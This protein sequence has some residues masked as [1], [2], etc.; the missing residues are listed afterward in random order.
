MDKKSSLIQ[1]FDE[2]FKKTTEANKVFFTEGAKYIKQMGSSAMKGENVYA[3]QKNIIQDAVNAFIKLNIQH[4]SNLIDLGL[5]I[6]QKINEPFEVK[7]EEPSENRTEENPPAFILEAVGVPGGSVQTEFQLDNSKDES[8]VCTFKQSAFESQQ[9]TSSS[10]NIETTFSPQSFE[11]KIGSSQ[12]VT[13]N[14]TIPEKTKTGVYTSH[15]LVEGFE[16]TYFSIILT[17][18]PPPKQVAKRAMSKKKSQ[19]K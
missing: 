11:L 19:K 15:V 7:K 12:K 4:T 10:V 18:A 1:D 17:I 2:L 3:E 16:H 6:T 9:D 8:I 5:A 13:I 14:I